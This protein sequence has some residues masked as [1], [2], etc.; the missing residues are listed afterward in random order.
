MLKATRTMLPLHFFCIL[1]IIT[2]LFS[3]G[4]YSLS[5]EDRQEENDHQNTWQETHHEEACGEKCGSFHIPFPFY[6]NQSNCGS[7][8][9]DAFRLSCIN[10]TS[11]F[12]NIGSQTYQLL[13]F[14]SDG[15]L[16]DF[17]NTTFCRQY[18]DL[19]SFGF[20]GNDNFGISRDNILGLYDC[21]DSSLCKP[22]CEKN[23]MPRCDGSPGSYPACCYPLSDRSAWNADQRDGFSTFSQF[24]CRGFSSWVV[25]SGNQVGKR[26]VKLEWAVPRNSTTAT[27]ATN[28]DIVNATTVASGIRCK[29]QDGFVGDGFA[30]GVG[31]LKSCIKEGKEAYGKACSSTSHGRRKAVILAGVLTSA[32][33]I[34]SLTALF[35]VLRR[36][37]KT[38]IF[39]HPSMTRSQGNISFQKPC[40]IRMFTYYELEQ[41]T[42]G[43]QD[44]QILLDHGGKATLYSGTLVDASA[45]AVHRLQCDS[46][47]ELVEVLSRVEALH[48]VSHKNIAQ[49]LGWSVDSGYTPL[50]VYV[51]PVNGTLG[52]HLFRAKDETKRGLDW[53][54]R[55]NIVAETANVLAFLQ[56]EVY[57]PI[58]HHELNASCIFL[59]EDLTVK[60][61]GLELSTNASTDYK[62]QSDVYNF[63]LVLLEVITGSSSD[64]V[65]SK[66]ALQKITSGKLEEIVDPHLY[67]HEQP[68]FR[69]EQ[70]EIV[71]DLATRCIIFGSQDGKFHM[72]DVARE[73]VHISKDGVD[74]RSR[75]CPSTH[76]L[77]ETF[78]NSS[79]LQMIS[80]SP[81]SIHVP[82]RGFS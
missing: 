29:C 21:E 47:R 3:S 66:T 61:F 8:L 68:I 82:A 27:C 20:K 74:G 7:S 64:H 49:I 62:K 73:L 70:I 14:F 5:H 80:M 35:C 11:L 28:A 43:F 75:R 32:L 79:L 13:H 65:P 72:G 12:L 57:P 16:V 45:I 37:M 34:T 40:T 1:L 53:H 42:K 25:L 52:E 50:V 31:C 33:T 63:G 60:L 30:V 4:T 59:D 76:N 71:A 48:A 54:Q 51:Y 39:D 22:D 69:R 78:S 81:D 56:S 77:E 18:N 9:S 46:E 67:Y 58:V 24:G 6:M 17:P 26:G 10:S 2:L 55:I 23:I 15:V 41:A 38:D 36:P 19:K 44:D